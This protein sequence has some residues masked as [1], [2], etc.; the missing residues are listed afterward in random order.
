MTTMPDY[1]QVARIKVFGIGGGVYGAK[2]STGFA[3]NIRKAICC[4]FRVNCC[5]NKSISFIF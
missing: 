2:A 5:T 3:R 1:N 4:G